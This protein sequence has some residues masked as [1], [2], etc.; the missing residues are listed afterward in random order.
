MRTSATGAALSG[1]RR[2][3]GVVREKSPRNCAQLGSEVRAPRGLSREGGF[4]ENAR[5]C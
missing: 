2:G 4:A 3:V 1:E 5:V